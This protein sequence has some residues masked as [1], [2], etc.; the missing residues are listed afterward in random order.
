M[1]NWNLN[2]P[3]LSMQLELL[4]PVRGNWK[5]SFYCECLWWKTV[6]RIRKYFLR[7]CEVPV[8]LKLRLWIQEANRLRILLDNF[9]FCGQ[10]LRKLQQEVFCLL[11]FEGTTT[12]LHHS[13]RIKSHKEV[14]KE[15]KSRFF[16][17]GFVQNND[18][19]GRFKNIRI[20]IRI[21]NTV[22]V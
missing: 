22:Q 3:F 6:F 14:T 16:L 2:L 15:K 9:D 1:G 5:Q 12:K 7:I 10:V 4:L 18:G 11:L 8:D 13:L 20:Q 21:H 19:S 17:S